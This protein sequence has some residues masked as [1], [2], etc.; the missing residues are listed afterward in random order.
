MDLSKPP[1]CC[2]VLRIEIGTLDQVT[3][4]TLLD[5]VQV[6][7]SRE[8]VGAILTAFAGRFCDEVSFPALAATGRRSWQSGSTLANSGWHTRLGYPLDQGDPNR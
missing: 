5:R 3:R 6:V 8:E 1:L 7:L 2:H 4:A